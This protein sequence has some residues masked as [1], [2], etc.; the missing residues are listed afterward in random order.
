VKKICVFASGNGSNAENIIRYFQ[1][2]N[3]IAVS[4]IVTNNPQAG[5][6]TRARNLGVPVLIC[7]KEEMQAP[8]GLSVRLQQEG[9]DLIVLAGF[10]RLIPS[11]LLNAFAGRLVNIHPALLP[12]FGGKGM[13]GMHVHEAVIRAGEKES[14]I[15]IHHVNEEY[16]KGEVLLR[17]SCSVLPG[18]TPEALSAR[19]Q[20]LE[21][22]HYP[23]VIESLL[24][25]G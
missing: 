11:A 6:I 8:E 18:D 19:I 24:R 13:Y 15:T 17:K 2:R 21:H 20:E 25:A 16:D 1:G 22:L 5:V 14:G 10:M 7:G 3:D 9:I 12:K 23:P 4:L